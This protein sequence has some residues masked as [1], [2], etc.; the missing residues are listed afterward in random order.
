M[1]C[2]WRPPAEVIDVLRYNSKKLYFVTNNATHSRA[3]MLKKFQAL[4]LKAN[5]VGCH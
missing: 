2:R 4:G 3:S 5:L 1:M